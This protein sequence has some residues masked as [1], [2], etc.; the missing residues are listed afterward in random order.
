MEK[1][2]AIDLKILEH[3]QA[4][5][6]ITTKDLARKIALS[7]T[8][9]YERVR[10]LEKEG[11][12]SRYMALLNREKLGKHLI[13]FC[14]VNLKEHARVTGKL[15]EDE[16]VN[17]EEVT[18]CYSISGDYDFMLKVVV[19]DMKAYQNF[20]MDKLGAIH[21]IASSHSTFVMGEVK[22]SYGIPLDR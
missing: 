12:I 21:C 7:P 14:H 10:R 18:E 11:Y 17:L 4:N 9:V 15:F 22:Q 19:K 16:I 6:D 2:D 20:L 8:P 3:L 5:S 13:V 1:L